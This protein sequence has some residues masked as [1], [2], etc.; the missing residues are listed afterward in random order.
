MAVT[1]YLTLLHAC[2][3]VDVGSIPEFEMFIYFENDTNKLFFQ[4]S[5]LIIDDALS[6]TDLTAD[7][8]MTKKV[9]S[10]LPYNKNFRF[11]FSSME[12]LTLYPKIIFC[13]RSSCCDSSLRNKNMLRSVTRFLFQ[14]LAI[15]NTEHLP[16]TMKN[17]QSRFNILPNMKE[18]LSKI[19]K[20]Y[21]MLAKVAKFR[22]IWS[23]W[24]WVTLE[25]RWNKFFL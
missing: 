20:D 23:H 1:Y 25:I 11:K 15:Y 6:D 9:P 2:Q 12:W 10:E 4:T 19:A 14:Y 17:G 24:C 13:Q 7:I 16:Y 8:Y 18:T 5:M 3:S 22:Q 21:K